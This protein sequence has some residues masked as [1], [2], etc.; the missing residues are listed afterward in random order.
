MGVKQKQNDL[1][2]ATVNKNFGKRSS[3]NKASSIG[4]SLPS[5]L[6]EYFSSASSKTN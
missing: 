6:K 5:E 3:R 4:N 2:L 1:H